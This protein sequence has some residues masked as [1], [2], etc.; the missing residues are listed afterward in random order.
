[1]LTGDLIEAIRSTLRDEFV[2][3][4]NGGHFLLMT[5][6][7][8]EDDEA[9]F[10]TL[11]EDPQPFKGKSRSTVSRQLSVLSLQKAP[12]NPYPDRISVGRARNC[13]VALRDPSVSKLHAH[14]KVRDGGYDL[15]DLDSQNGTC[16]NGTK[17]TPHGPK[18]VSS[19]DVLLFGHV[20]CKLVNAGLLYDLLR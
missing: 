16:V 12:G 5:T 20:S 19:G 10:D 8:D 3:A 7:I 17:L 9:G 11:V 2:A 14:F 13:D 1:M 4:Q 15:I 6:R 18:T